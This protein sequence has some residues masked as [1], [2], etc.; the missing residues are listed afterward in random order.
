M[1]PCPGRGPDN[2]GGLAAGPVSYQDWSRQHVV[3]ALLAG[4]PL[5]AVFC[6]IVQ[7]PLWN[8]GN[9]G[10]VVANLL[11]TVSFYAT[12]VF[13]YVEPGHRLT[14]AGLAA[15]AF[16]WPVNWINEWDVG[17]FPLLAALEGPLAALIAV[18]A[19]LRYP[20]PWS[21][22]RYEVITIVTLLLVQGGAALQV[23]TSLPQWRGLP[24]YT[25]W[26][27]WWPDERAYAQAQQ[28]YNDG[29]VVASVAVVLALVLRL[30]RL[31]GPDRLVMRPVMAGIVI[32]GAL[33]AASGVAAALPMSVPAVRT[34]DTLEGIALI[35]VPVTFVVASARRWLARERVP[36]L[37]RQL[38]PSPTPASVQEALRQAL[39]DPGLR[40]LYRLGGEYVDINGVPQP[41]PPRQDRGV[42][43][44]MSKSAAAHVALLTANPV[45]LRYHEVVQAAARVATLALEN[46]SLQASIMAQIHRVSASADR[47][48]SAVDAERRSI[49]A[50]V[51]GICTSELACLSAYLKTLTEGHATA[52]IASQL[53]S[54]QD[55]LAQAQHE[56][57]NLS[58]GLGPA[59]LTG[60]RLGES[61]AAAARRLNTDITVD[62]TDEALAPDLAEA[63]YLLLSELMTNA[64]K[65]APGSVI[66]VRVVQEESELVLQ[67][68]DDGP[69]GADP[70]GSGLQGVRGRVSELSGSLAISSPCGI[71]TRVL[72]R[73][74]VRNTRPLQSLSA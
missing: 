63:V 58:R 15:A 70:E 74:P 40:L 5:L 19:L 4:I 57:K 9:I 31:T 62:V 6:L 10:L 69:G 33:T 22:R 21:R 23:V 11:V 13:V 72:I 59:G 54:V 3:I 12:A 24:Q 14:G 26:L 68:T 27:A 38:G 29:V 73:L 32:A 36:R 60:Q 2:Q 53:T 67:V 16:L 39:A 66:A 52:G 51:D 71:G 56:L 42:A 1:R 65:H 55:L 45:G 50:A 17:P 47:L 8:P 44:V 20:V 25:L 35:G 30:A 46:T 48:A 61:V 18:W 64:V 34:L 49:R 7:W 41:D 28:V 43:V 37:I